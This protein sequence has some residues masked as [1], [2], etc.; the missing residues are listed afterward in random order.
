[1]KTLRDYLKNN[2]K[3]F[4]DENLIDYDELMVYIEE[5]AEGESL[6]SFDYLSLELFEQS[7]TTKWIGSKIEFDKEDF[8]ILVKEIEEEWEN[9]RRMIY[10]PN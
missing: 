9:E 7:L 6:Y 8:N 1:M 3:F 5:Q 10:F 2:D 4:H